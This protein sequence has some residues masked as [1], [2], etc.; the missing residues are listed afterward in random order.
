MEKD[1][2]SGKVDHQTFWEKFKEVDLNLQGLEEKIAPFRFFVDHLSH[3]E[4]GL[5]Q[6][7]SLETRCTKCRPV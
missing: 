6:V 1:R 5:C 4:D 2:L 7:A 3:V